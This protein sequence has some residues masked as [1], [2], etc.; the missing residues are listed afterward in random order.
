MPSSCS[1]Y[2][3]S[4][5]KSVQSKHSDIRALQDRGYTIGKKIGKG[6]YATVVAA[7]Y[8]NKN[9]KIP[10]ACK[11]VDKSRAPSDFLNK[12]LPRELEIIIKLEHPYIIQIHSILQRGPK[13]FIFMRYAEN[14]DLLEYIKK[15]GAI[16][17]YGAKSWFYQLVKGLKYL[18]SQ[19]IAHRDLKCENIL[20]SKKMNIKIADFGFA[21]HCTDNHGNNLFSLTYCGSAAYAAPEIVNGCPYDPKI[22]DIWSLGVILFIML[23]ATM[24]FDDKN[25][26]KLLQDQQNRNYH[27][28]PSIER[29][30]T[31]KCK[32]LVDLILDP[33][34][35]T[36]WTLDRIENSRWFTDSVVISEGVPN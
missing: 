35:K 11:I 4:L 17:E 18:H 8:E 1:S 9:H 32:A 25:V 10:L 26:K 27:F 19:N 31:T 22:A 30:L 28:R 33:D 29:R 21:R 14:G 2:S 12:F 13:I 23:N 15:N 34:V 20:I 24:P 16:V 3:C 7:F 36:R 6:S 5:T